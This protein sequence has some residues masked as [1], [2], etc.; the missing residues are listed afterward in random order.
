ML[1]GCADLKLDTADFYHSPIFSGSEYDGIGTW[2]DPSNDY[3]L[4][5]G[6]LKD[7]VVA[8]PVP[9]HIR[10][11]FTVQP[12]IDGPFLSANGPPLPYFALKMN[13]TFTKDIVEA[14]IDGFTGD[15]FSFHATLENFGGPHPGVHEILGGDMSGRCPFGLGPPQCVPG[16]KWA[17]NGE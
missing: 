8:Y 17:P 7:I 4:Y 1:N 15:Y 2:G 14:L 9:H 13:V 16:Q 12:F 5:D 10:R 3:Q 11:N 6:G